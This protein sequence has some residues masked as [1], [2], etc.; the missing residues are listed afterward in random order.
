ME[1][2]VEEEDGVLVYKLVAFD[3]VLGH[4]PMTRQR[5]VPFLMSSVAAH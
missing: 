1:D 3:V 2:A 5:S 4:K